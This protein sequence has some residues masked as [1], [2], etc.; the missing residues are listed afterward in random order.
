MRLQGGKERNTR[1]TKKMQRIMM[2]IIETRNP[3]ALLLLQPLVA[4]S[5]LFG[6]G[7]GSACMEYSFD[8]ANNINIGRRGVFLRRFAFGS[9]FIA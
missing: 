1:T 7:D 5:T 6:Y 9:G 4:I 2:T 8:N 3:V